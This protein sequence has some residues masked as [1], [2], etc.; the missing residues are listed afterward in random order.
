MNFGHPLADK[1]LLGTE[2]FA[3][4]AI[5]TIAGVFFFREPVAVSKTRLIK[6]IVHGTLVENFEVTGDVNTIWAR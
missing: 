1:D 3:I 4:F 2:L 5:Q 6:F